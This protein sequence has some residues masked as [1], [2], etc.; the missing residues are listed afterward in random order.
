MKRGGVETGSLATIIT[1]RKAASAAGELVRIGEPGKLQQRRSVFQIR[2]RLTYTPQ[3]GHPEIVILPRGA[4]AVSHARATWSVVPLLEHAFT[5]MTPT[6]KQLSRGVDV[7]KVEPTGATFIARTKEDPE[8]VR[9]DRSRP[10]HFYL[11]DDATGVETP[12]TMLDSVLYPPITPASILGKTANSR[13]MIEDGAVVRR[14][15]R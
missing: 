9:T 1:E 8:G 13:L 2:P 12:L 7:N 6:A 3:A 11:R 15:Q 5:D 4:D 10:V 14:P